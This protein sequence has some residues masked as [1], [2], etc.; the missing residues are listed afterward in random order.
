MEDIFDILDHEPLRES[1]LFYSSWYKW[2]CTL[3]VRTQSKAYKAICDY[4]FFNAPIPKADFSATEYATL[5]SFVPTID[6]HKR[7]YENGKKGAP[8]GIK[9]GRPRKTETPVGL[10]SETG[11]GLK[12]LTPTDTVTATETDKETATV[13][14]A[15]AICFSPPSFQDLE[16]ELLPIFFFKNNCKPGQELKKFYDHYSRN[17]WM[18]SGGQLLDTGEKRKAAAEKWK[19]NNPQDAQ[20]PPLFM[21]VWK[22]IYRSVPPDLKPDAIR[23]KSTSR[24]QAAITIVCS[25]ALKEWRDQPDVNDCIMAM[26]SVRIS[27]NYKFE[28]YAKQ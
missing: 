21:G 8:S 2:I 13:T 25:S 27:P 23:I 4:C 22:E 18:L 11:V 3:K 6:K 16:D 14:A 19:V 20:F 10:S 28:Y 12:T 24:Q 17:G 15:S 1:F 7:N 26:F 5:C 9:G